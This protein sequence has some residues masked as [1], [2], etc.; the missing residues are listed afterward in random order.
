MGKHAKLSAS[1]SHRWFLCPASVKAEA[2]YPDK[3]STFAE[4]GTLAHSIADDLLQKKVVWCE[5][6]DMLRH[7]QSYCEYVNE[8]MEED[9]ILFT[10]SRVDFSKWVDS[11]FGTCDCAIINFRDRTCHIIDLKYGK[12]V[13]VDV[14]ENTQLILYALGFYNNYIE[15]MGEIDN[16]TLHIYQPR[17]YNYSQWNISLSELLQWGDK[18]KV[19]SELTKYDNAPLVAGDKQCKFCKANADCKA[20]SELTKKLIS[21]NFDDLSIDDNKRFVLDNENLI[22][23]HIKSVKESVYNKLSKGEEFTGYKLVEGRSIRKYLETA[24]EVL[25]EKLEDKAFEKKLIPITTAEKLIGKEIINEITYKP[26]GKL[27]I[28]KTE[29][30]R[31]EVANTLGFEKIDT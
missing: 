28:V 11:G 15:G 10:E 4:E 6:E 21:F 19:A 7:C 12:G 24:E 31:P 2:K 22:T 5:D 29:D 18:L 16:F 9:S 13:E 26:V 20:L 1:S 30:K 3:T 23:S 27:V 8:Y 25:K 17:L 14:V